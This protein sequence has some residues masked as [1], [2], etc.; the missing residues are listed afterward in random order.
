MAVGRE[1]G[2]NLTVEVNA[3]DVLVTTVCRRWNGDSR[4]FMYWNG[5][6]NTASF[7]V[8]VES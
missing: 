1:M 2:I 3:V 6:F 8:G 5:A 7:D 4:W